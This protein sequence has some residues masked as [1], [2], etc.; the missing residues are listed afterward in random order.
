MSKLQINDYI[1]A[2]PEVCHGKPTF[3]GTRV[4]VWQVLE[5]L[6]AG[7]SEQN[8]LQNFPSLTNAHIMAAFNYASSL[9]R[10]SYVIVNTHSQI[11]A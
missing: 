7:R 5:M 9:T 1:V 2:D 4:M 8:V 6:A 3:S 10:E 11:F